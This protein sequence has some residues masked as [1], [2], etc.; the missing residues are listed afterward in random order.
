MCVCVW[1]GGGFVESIR[2][3]LNGLRRK[4]VDNDFLTYIFSY[5]L[6]FLGETCYLAKML[7]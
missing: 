3:A 4:L 2:F 7:P 6:I 1:G 5:D